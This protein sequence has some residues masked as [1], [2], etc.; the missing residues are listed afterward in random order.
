[1]GETMNQT[2]RAGR[3]IAAWLVPASDLAGRLYLQAGASQWGLS[4][5]H[6]SDALTRSA[7]RRFSATM[8]TQEEVAQYASS[9]QLEDL[10]L[11]C[12][13]AT[14]IEAAWDHFI[15]AYRGYL[16]AAA[17]AILRRNADSPEA[18]ELADSI[19]AELYGWRDMK[20]GR[21]SLFQ[22]FHGRSK[23]TTWLRAV[24]AQRHVDAIRRA[25][26]FESL[27]EDDAQLRTADPGRI[28]KR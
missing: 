28:V 9:L 14:G 5:E 19:H 1:M 7:C 25:K 4:P 8:P 10:A 27:E 15:P 21:L 17:G 24:L 23:L 2:E 20:R 22:Y 13:C 26:K 12:A 6:F 18:R 3:Q 16:R 11:A